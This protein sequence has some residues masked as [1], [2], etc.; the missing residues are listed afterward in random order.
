VP[1]KYGNLQGQEYLEWIQSL[2][3]KFAE[4]LSDSGSLVMEIGNAWNAKS[5]T[6]STLP[7][8][9]LMSVAKAGEMHICQQMI[10]H[11]PGK[12]PGPATWVNVRRQR[13]TDSYTHIWWF[14]RT[15]F[16]KADNR[17]VLTPYT[18]SMKKLIKNK[19]YNHGTRPSGHVIS[20]KGFLGDKGGSIPRSVLSFSNTGSDKEY[21][22]WCELRKLSKHPARMPINLADFFINLLTDKGDLVLDPFGGSCTTGKSAENLE[23]KWIC[24]EP[25]K[26]YLLGA[27]GRFQRSFKKTRN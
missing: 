10:W 8:E 17:K 18:E 2:S 25:N 4:L 23:R 5:P 20:K 19:K 21:R 24:V 22:E 15:E 9:T 13:I 27:Q 12:L 1:K 11:N 26:E 16:P 14:S 7:I 3:P 6:M